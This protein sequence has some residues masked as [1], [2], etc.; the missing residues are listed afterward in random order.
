MHKKDKK[1][2]QKRTPRE[3]IDV[4]ETEHEAQTRVVRVLTR[5]GVVF[6][7]VPNG[8]FRQKLSA[9]RLKREGVVSGVP[10]LLIF[11]PPPL[12]PDVRG[13]A[14]EM[15][16]VKGRL[17]DK[18]KAF[19]KKLEDCHWVCFVCRGSDEALKLLT[20]LGYDQLTE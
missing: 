1:S 6:C 11:T 8:G 13:V 15:K 18:Q 7:A 9:V 19:I 10:D 16:T 12:R 2:V 5:L 17:S 20:V 14:I 4:S 3:I